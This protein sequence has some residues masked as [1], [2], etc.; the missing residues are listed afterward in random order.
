MHGAM[1]AHTGNSVSVQPGVVAGLE[2]GGASGAR[3]IVGQGTGVLTPVDGMRGSY[4]V[5]SD[6]VETINLAPPDSV[7]SRRD[8]I[9]VRVRDAAFGDSTTG[10]TIEAVTGSP[11]VSPVAPP[12]PD[13]TLLLGWAVVPPSGAVSV[14]DARLWT[15]AIGGAMSGTREQRL[16]LPTT[17]LR[18]GQTWTENA[19]SETG[20]KGQTWRWNG[21]LWTPQFVQ[22]WYGFMG[23]AQNNFQ[24]V[25]ADQLDV[26]SGRLI[27][28]P[29]GKATGSGF[30]ERN[31]LPCTILSGRNVAVPY[32]GRYKVKATIAAPTADATF[33]LGIYKSLAATTADQG[34]VGAPK[35]GSQLLAENKGYVGP[36]SLPGPVTLVTTVEQYALAAGDTLSPTIWQGS[37]STR[38]IWQGNPYACWFEIKRLGD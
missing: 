3:V 6:A 25:V 26:P 22:G 32:P 11:S 24:W 18:P 35:P 31:D 19:D 4:L 9:V 7:Y 38:K 33:T 20:R 17:H 37:G 21:E 2:A 36:A 1:F 5:A 29:I 10:A 34:A 16:A 23:V 30:D 13:G 27:S 14:I 12:V 28:I 8:A 15:S